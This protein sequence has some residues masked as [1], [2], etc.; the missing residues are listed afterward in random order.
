MSGK[1]FYVTTPIY[2][3][4]DK[5]HLGHAYTTVATDAKARFHRLRGE[6]ARMLTGTDEHG[7]KLEQAALDA[8]KDTLTFA[9][10]NSEKFRALW[11]K[12]NIRCDDYI[13]TTEERHKR[14]VQEIWRRVR[15]A[16][17]IY[18]DE[19]EGKYCVS[20][21]N[22]LTDLQLDDGKCPDCGRPAESVREESYFFSLSKFQAPLLAYYKSHPEFI[23]P[24]GRRKEIVSFVAGGL[25]DLSVSRT[26]F[27]WGIPV[28]DD[29]AH[30]IY[31]WFDA[32]S[33]YATAAGFGA[34]GAEESGFPEGT[35]WPADQHFIGKDILRFH[36]VYW[37]AFLMSAGLPL[38]G[39][40]F[41]HGW[42]TIEGQ[43]MSKSLGNAVDP[44][45]LIEE[46]G[47]DAFRYFILRE[48]PFGSDGDFSHAQLIDR[49]NSDLANDLGNLLYRTL[50]M[51]KRYR[52]GRIIRGGAALDAES[53]KTLVSAAVDAA[54]RYES[55][56]EATDL[57]SGLRAT[58]E[59]IS[60]ANKYIDAAAPWALA[61][62]G[63]EE[64]LDSV[65]Y[66]AGAALRVVAA[67]ISPVMP[68][69]A[70]SIAHQLG[71][72]EDWLAAP[73]GELMDLYALPESLETKL[74]K[75][76]FPRIEDDARAA[77]EGK[78]AAR[79]SE[80]ES[81]SAA[82]ADPKGKAPGKKKEKRGDLESTG[83]ITIEG[84]RRVELRTARVE[85][86]ENIP[87]SKNLL[88]LEVSLGEERRTIVAGVA[89]FYEPAEL[90]GRAVVVVANLEPAKIMG[91]ESQ[92][93]LLA[94]KDDDGLKLVGV[95]DGIT[96][97]SRVS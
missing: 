15:E 73:F 17:D 36:A 65:L 67:M 79:I 53:E 39:Q 83:L 86:A 48:I 6:A 2:Y 64:R 87:K 54:W 1:P 11:K 96:S 27:K 3:V 50:N 71:L 81:D 58:W 23:Q 5:P 16:G 47:V 44:H 18:K 10:E 55:E 62:S 19:Y 32:L 75:P 91:V 89:K 66:H 14:G 94:A 33:N 92:G 42:W 80:G 28:P 90:I 56:M 82:E 70:D 20:C 63:P 49:I 85:A 57:Q 8:G 52:G 7:Q 4:N 30:V 74:G 13:R 24:E 9:T 22:F 34:E 35:A 21:E 43:K 78:V 59:I 26:S 68:E 88:K 51:V 69:T 72:A 60:A 97:G 29:P 40:I 95:P 45:W 25:R 61:K 12:L 37:P 84:F 46:Y 77:L 93:M 38:P 31:V 76:L 41:S